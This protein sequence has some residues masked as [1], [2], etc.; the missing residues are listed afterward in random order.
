MFYNYAM[1]IL[2][3]ADRCKSTLPK[4]ENDFKGENEGETNERFNKSIY[5]Q[6]PKKK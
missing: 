4:V 2:E 5:S 1:L 3:V 6:T